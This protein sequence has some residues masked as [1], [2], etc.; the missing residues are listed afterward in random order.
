MLQ[1]LDS[2]LTQRCIEDIIS[3]YR[4]NSTEDA[5][6]R[7]RISAVTDLKLSFTRFL[8]DN[9]DKDVLN[10]GI[11]YLKDNYKEEYALLYSIICEYT[12]YGLSRYLNDQQYK[13]IQQ[14]KQ[15]TNG[16]TKATTRQMC[17]QPS[18]TSSTSKLKPFWVKILKCFKFGE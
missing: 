4:E 2:L 5:P 10:Y 17:E 3:T 11:M 12:N 1:I 13:N 18:P 9:D 6:D 7:C 15:N 8:L 16:T 14:Q